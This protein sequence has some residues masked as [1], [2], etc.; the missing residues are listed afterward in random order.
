MTQQVLLSSFQKSG[1]K[2]VLKGSMVLK[3]VK[4]GLKVV[5]KGSKSGKKMAKSGLDMVKKCFKKCPKR[6]S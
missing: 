5:Q 2:V 6:D 1:L 4:K 3:R